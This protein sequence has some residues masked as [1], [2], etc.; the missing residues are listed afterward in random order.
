MIEIGKLISLLERVLGRQRR[1]TRRYRMSVAARQTRVTS[2]SQAADEASGVR[3]TVGN[4]LDRLMSILVSPHGQSH[5][6]ILL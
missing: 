6:S 2:F 4:F 1:A 5:T 3:N